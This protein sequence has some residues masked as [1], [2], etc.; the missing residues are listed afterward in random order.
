M[1]RFFSLLAIITMMAVTGTAQPEV[2]LRWGAH[3]GLNYN[4]A[5]AGYAEW[6]VPDSTRPYGYYGNFVEENMVDGSGIG[7]YGGLSGQ[8]MLLKNLGLQARLSYDGRSMLLK[9]DV[10][11][12]RLDGT[13]YS[14]EFDFNIALL[15]IEALVKLYFGKQ[16]H[17]TGGVGLGYLLSKEYDYT[18]DGE[19]TV[20]GNTIPGASFAPSVVFGFGYDIYMSKPTDKQQWILTPFAEV[21]YVMNMRGDLIA[22]DQSDLDDGLSIATLRAGLGIAFGDAKLEQA[23]V[24]ATPGFDF[25]TSLPEG[26]IATDAIVDERYPILPYVFFEKGNTEIPSRYSKLTAAETSSFPKKNMDALTGS[27]AEEY[28]QGEVYYHILNIIGYRMRGNSSYT[29][30]LI[31][32]D[33]EEKN[34]QDLANSVKKYLV[35]VWG[36]DGGRITAT[37][38]VN[39]RV[40]SGTDRTPPADRPLTQEENRRVELVPNDPTLIRQAQIKVSRKATIEN[41]ALIT[42]NSDAPVANW[43]ANFTNASGKK[44]TYGP[45]TQ[46]SQYIDVMQMIPDGSSTAD[47]S[48]EVIAKMNDGTTRSATHPVEFERRSTPAQSRN[49]S[50]LFEYAEEDP[51]GR[52]K[53][54]LENTVAKEIES[55]S[56]VR[57]TGA[58]DNIGTED[59]NLRISIGRASEVRDI[60]RGAFTAQGKSGMTVESEGVGE[61]TREHQYPNN[62]PEGRMYNR[63]VTIHTMPK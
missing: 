38:Q 8:W 49:Y 44:Y 29:L 45:F 34:G 31:G 7:I 11:Y 63:S 54:F 53:S 48:C 46:S 42:I 24:P 20:A 14:D 15:N 40:P 27:E 50:L 26:G 25:F 21:S 23:A 10:S 13:A 41:D 43:T 18:A 61:G 28:I 56:F 32:S 36:I 17:M 19:S 22:D 3:L 1:K 6:G 4:M 37:G 51:I 35:D 52:R 5:G 12:S 58:T 55:N 30:N 47:Y 60:L 57:I 16:F 2:P 39:P 62:L 9:D 33:P 59:A